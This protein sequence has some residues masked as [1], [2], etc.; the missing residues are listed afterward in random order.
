[1]SAGRSSCQATDSSS[2]LLGMAPVSFVSNR[3]HI[4]RAGCTEQPGRVLPCKMDSIL[5]EVG[6]TGGKIKSITRF[7]QPPEPCQC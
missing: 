2:M 7:N 5:R 6:F 4:C 3:S 1:M